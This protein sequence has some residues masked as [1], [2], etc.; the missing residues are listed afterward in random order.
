M[1]TRIALG[2]LGVLGILFG[3][4]KLLLDHQN[5]NPIHLA[6]WLGGSAVVNDAVLVPLVGIVGLIV[7]RTVPG[8]ARPYVQGGLIA[9]ALST[10]IAI[11]LIYRRDTQPDSKALE[12][13][14]YLGNLAIIIAAIVVVTTALII[15]S[16]LKAGRS[17]ENDR[18]PEDHS[19]TI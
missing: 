9:A 3:G 12:Q 18:S 1:R 11:P 7:T 10:V 16:Y 4:I 15:V 8:G 17:A 6:I 14:N 2:A 19:S 5:S 13:Q